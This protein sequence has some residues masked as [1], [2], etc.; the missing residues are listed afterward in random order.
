MLTIYILPCYFTLFYPIIICILLFLF[1]PY[2]KCQFQTPQPRDLTL[3][4]QRV[5]ALFP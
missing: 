3:F 5:I 4:W 1:V 2:L